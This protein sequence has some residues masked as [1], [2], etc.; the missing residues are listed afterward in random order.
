MMRTSG[1]ELTPELWLIKES[2]KC[3]Y[4]ARSEVLLTVPTVAHGK[5][6]FEL[7]HQRSVSRCFS[8][9]F[10]LIAFPQTRNKRTRAKSVPSR[11]P[12]YCATELCVYNDNMNKELTLT[13][14]L[15]LACLSL[16]TRARQLG[17]AA[18]LAFVAAKAQAA[19]ARLGH[20]SRS[21]ANYGRTGDPTCWRNE[22]PSASPHDLL[23][24]GWRRMYLPSKYRTISPREQ[25]SPHHP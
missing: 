11:C 19:T 17:R 1:V 7:R 21:N 15:S 16:I 4:A 14:C 18:G 10:A 25:I 12:E 2:S 23:F 5:H 9:E 8:G 3:R 20:R 24:P 6:R 22:A 13:D